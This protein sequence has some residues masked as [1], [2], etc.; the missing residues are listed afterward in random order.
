MESEFVGSGSTRGEGDWGWLTDYGGISSLRSEEWGIAFLGCG[1][2]GE[3]VVD[4]FVEW[5]EAG[6]GGDHCG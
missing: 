5:G 2:G 1:S 4:V 6:G 3:E